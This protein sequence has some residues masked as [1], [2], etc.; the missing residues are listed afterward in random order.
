MSDPT[1]HAPGARLRQLRDDLRAGKPVDTVALAGTLDQAARAL[2]ASV[3]AACALDDLLGRLDRVDGSLEVRHLRAW[4][5][6]DAA[7]SARDGWADL[8]PEDLG[9]R[10]GGGA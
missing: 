8:D 6:L 3:L 9:A 4:I 5:E 2:D 1:P 7:H 10:D